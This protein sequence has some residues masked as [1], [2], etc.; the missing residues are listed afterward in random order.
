M[1]DNLLQI[2]EQTA[3]NVQG[4]TK[5]MGI[6]ATEIQ[7]MQ[8][9]QR[10]FAEELG[11]FRDRMQN[12]ED[13][14]RVTRPQAQNIRQSIHARAAELLDIK[15][16]NGVVARESLFADKYYRSGFISRCYSDARNQSRLGTPYTETY[17][18]DYRDV[19]DYIGSWIPPMGVERYK[20][21][22]DDRRSAKGE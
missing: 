9:E 14:V 10:R 11:S 12:Y 2:V 8:V 16:E 5:Q 22:L 7:N 1:S 17:Q 21:Y 4:I 15:Y 20:K 6:I 13:R 3:F 19:L 18:K